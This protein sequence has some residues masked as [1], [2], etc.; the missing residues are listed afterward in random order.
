MSGTP[1]TVPVNEICHA[2]HQHCG[3]LAAFSFPYDEALIPQN[4]IYVLFEDGEVA[5]GTGRIVRIGTHTGN[6]QLRSRL[7]QHFLN[8]NKDRSIFRKNVGRCLLK[9]ENDPFLASWEL[10]LTTRVAKDQ[11]SSRIDFTKQDDVEKQVSEYIQRHLRFVVFEVHDKAR[12]LDLESKL[13]STVSLCECCGP[14]ETWL[15]RHSPK[16]KISTGK[17]WQVNEL[18]KSPLSADELTERFLLLG[19]NAAE[20]TADNTPRTRSINDTPEDLLEQ[21]WSGDCFG[22]AMAWVTA[23]E[24]DDWL[25]VHG[26]VLSERVG[27]RIEHAWCERD[28]F[29][30]DLAMPVGSRIIEREQYYRVTQPQVK[31]RY[32]SDDAVVLSLKN[33]H[34][35]PWG[36]PG[37]T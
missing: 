14:S 6:N 5:H 20:R 26:T 31:N 16:V 28:R 12:R 24:E 2:L 19:G 3:G 35:G 21:D 13:I 4:G 32:S 27:K 37:A 15:G 18:H 8:E 7:K 36:E 33:R 1:T 9:Q 25:V 11:Y 29:V 10:D 22:A 30:V 23:A 34:H 17:L